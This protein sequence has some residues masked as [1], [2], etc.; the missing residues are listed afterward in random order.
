MTST[1]CWTCDVWTQEDD[2]TDT[3]IK[4]TGTTVLYV[5]TTYENQVSIGLPIEDEIDDFGDITWRQLLEDVLQEEL[6]S[7]PELD[8]WLED[9]YGITADQLDETIDEEHVERWYDSIARSIDL[10]S[11]AGAQAY[12]LVRELAL[13]PVDEDGQGSANGV[14]LWFTISDGPRKYLIVDDDAAARWLLQACRE[15]GVA[16]DIQFV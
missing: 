6:P 2:V 4:G 9:N 3:Q 1:G 16:I 11:G 14:H 8:S 10:S 7:G 15:R 5:N 13:F 12:D